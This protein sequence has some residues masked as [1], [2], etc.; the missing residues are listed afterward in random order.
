[1]KVGLLTRYFDLRNAGIG[2]YSTELKEGLRRSGIAVSPVA[3]RLTSPAGYTM[4]TAL[5]LPLRLPHGCD[6]YHALS[7]YEAIYLPLKRKTVVTIHDLIPMLYAEKFS[8]DSSGRWR[9][10]RQ[11]FGRHYFQFACRRAVRCDALICISQETK[12]HV[13]RYLGIPES[14]IRIVPQGI[15]PQFRPLHT[16]TP[17]HAGI[18]RLGTLGVLDG[19]KR[20]DV[21]IRAFLDAN[22]PDAELIIGGEGEEKTRLKALARNDERI[23]FVGFVPDERLCEFYNSLDLLCFPT[24][25]EGYGLPIVEALACGVPV[26]TLE[27]ALIP[28]EVKRH[29][30]V[31]S[32]ARLADTLR[33]FEANRER[34][35]EGSI[36]WAQAHT[37]ERTVKETIM[38]YEWLAGKSP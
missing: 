27:D 12:N 32:A 4:Y 14:K 9:G 11:E 26:Q 19:R 18:F 17:G 15:G 1:M 7:P 13:V 37:W 22:L 30:I 3:T 2:R 16:R 34:P 23:K 33:A 6:I 28:A 10:F 21:L 35:C 24:A 29:T 36:R 8:W 38:L 25:I 20:L 5:G 31:T